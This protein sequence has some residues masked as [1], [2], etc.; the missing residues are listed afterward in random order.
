MQKEFWLERWKNKETAF[1]QKSTNP[2]LEKYLSQLSLKK[3]QRVFVPLCGKTLDI[4]H[5]I[6]Q[7]YEVVGVELSETAVEE[8]FLTLNLKPQ[9]TSKILN[10]KFDLYSAPHIEIFVG[11]IFELTPQLIGSIDAIYDRAALV[12]LP[13][14][15]RS[16]YAAQLISLTQKAPQLLICYDYDQQR[17]D[18]PPFS[19]CNDEINQLYQATYHTTLLES[20]VVE[21]GLKNKCEATENVWLLQPRIS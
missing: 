11:D 5:L 12:A 16:R 18:G 17:M 2:L 9:K 13:A 10:G 15:M 14:E 4:S 20:V 7:G 1:H 21:G 19:I 6:S 8:L 3:G